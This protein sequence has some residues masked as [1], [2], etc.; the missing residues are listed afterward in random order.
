MT[1]EPSAT[2]RFVDTGGHSTTAQGAK[3]THNDR[4]GEAVTI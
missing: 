3:V 1:T 2:A 4:A